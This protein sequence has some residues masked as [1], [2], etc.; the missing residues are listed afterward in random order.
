M[1]AGRARE[2]LTVLR[3]STGDLADELGDRLRK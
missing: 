1:M 2:C 3:W